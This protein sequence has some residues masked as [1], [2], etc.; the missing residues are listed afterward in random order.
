MKQYLTPSVT[1]LLL[2]HED[3]LNTSGESV[4]LKSLVEGESNEIFGGFTPYN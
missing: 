2:A 4:S 1:Y 3:I